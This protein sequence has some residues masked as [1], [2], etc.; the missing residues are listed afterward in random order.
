MTL[1]LLLLSGAGTL[2]GCTDSPTTQAPPQQAYQVTFYVANSSETQPATDLLIRW[3]T[4]VVAQDTFRYTNVSDQFQT[5]QL[6]TAPGEH[7]IRVVNH[8]NQL[9][10]D[11]TIIVRNPLTHVFVGFN[12]R[13]LDAEH[14]ER[15]GKNF[16]PDE[17]ALAIERLSEPKR[18][19]I[20]LMEGP[21]SIP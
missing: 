10:L 7:H 1:R 21:I 8:M 12:Y 9:R 15:I 5:Y 19:Y 13:Q 18:V 16:P 6:S 20:H 4:A 2:V 17:V 3:D 14:L 11:S